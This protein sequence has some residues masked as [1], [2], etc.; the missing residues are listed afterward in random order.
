MRAKSCLIIVFLMLLTVLSLCFSSCSSVEF[1]EGD[2]PKP[3]ESEDIGEHVH[4]FSEWTV[5]T[6]PTCTV[7]GEQIRRCA[8]CDFAESKR[9]D[10]VDHSWFDYHEGKE[11][12]CTEGGWTA[13]EICSVCGFSSK[14]ELPALEH[15]METVSAQDPGCE[16]IG[17]NEYEHCTRCGYSTM[18]EIEPLGHD[19]IHHSAKNPTCTEDGW[20]EYVTCSRCNYSTYEKIGHYG[21][22]INYDEYAADESS[23]F[24]AC[25]N[26]GCNEKDRAEEHTFAASHRCSICGYRQDSDD[27]TFTFEKVSGGYKITG[28]NGYSSSVNIPGTYNGETVVS[29]GDSV[30]MNCYEIQ[31]VNFMLTW[32][33]RIEDHA[34]YGCR[35]LST[36]SLDDVTHIGWSAFEG[37]TNLSVVTIGDKLE[38]I[39]NYAFAYCTSLKSIS[40]PDSLSTLGSGAFMF[41]ENLTSIHIPKMARFFPHTFMG[42]SSLSSVTVDPSSWYYVAG[43][44]CLIDKETKTLVLGCKDSVIPTDGSVTSI[45]HYAFSYRKGLKNIVIPDTVTAISDYA[46]E[47]TSLESVVIPNGVTEIGNGAFYECG[48]LKNVVIPDSVTTIGDYAFYGTSIESVIIPSGVTEIGRE[49][50][51]KCDNLN[52]VVIPDTV[53]IIGESAFFGCVELKELVIP[54]SVTVIGA[55]AFYNTSLE[56]VFI[57]NSVIE[58][59]WDAFSGPSDDLTRF[60]FENTTGWYFFDNEEK[61][62]MDV[63]DPEKNAEVFHTG[64]YSEHYIRGSVYREEG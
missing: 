39:D 25:K 58:I 24:F 4:S 16:A 3:E 63:S 9:L 11:P 29:I 1:D 28:Y 54:N 14:Q 7:E 20:A 59:G 48:N 34:F 30:F 26:E 32:V 38:W 46:F 53:T 23:H 6:Y 43:E 22:D 15:N 49:T 60:T 13:Y 47:H 5:V 51:Y 50:F 2:I 44:N 64:Y 31:S 41:C 17:W 52:S 40:L 62:M 18:V 42:C 56:S 19:E 45:G 61:I 55:S 36:I 37:C 10:T 57:P 27:P 35:N 33:E 8:S 12:T 21:H